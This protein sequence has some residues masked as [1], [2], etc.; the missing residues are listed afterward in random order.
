M[1]KRI[2]AGSFIIMW[3]NMLGMGLGI[4]IDNLYLII[5]FG[6]LAIFSSLI[7]LYAS[8]VLN[9]QEEKNEI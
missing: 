4:S 6:I 2:W 7:L 5:Y 1:I 3:I 9:E 8:C